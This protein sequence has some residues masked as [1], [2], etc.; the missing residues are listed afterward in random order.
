MDRVSFQE[1]LSRLH[2]VVIRRRR[3]VTAALLGLATVTGLDALRPATPPTAGVWVAAHD[4]TGGQALRS[5][6]LRIEQ[7]PRQDVPAGTFRPGES[8][9]GRLL[10]TPARTGE[11][12]TNV[13]LVSGDL[14]TAMGATG[15]VA[16]PI[17]VADAAATAAVTTAGAVIDV[18][19]ATGATGE[20]PAHLVASGLRVL[21]V[22]SRG[23]SH[24][25]GAVLVVAANP[26]Q[27]DTLAGA[28]ASGTLSI[29]LRRPA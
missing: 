11:P 29:V 19:A 1:L 27:A 28:A 5:A 6:D 7:L 26:R 12:I 24:D 9:V 8:L 25:G 20:Q 3:F 18:L 21:S 22:P 4:L 13:R 14:L 16:V 10:S 2:T 15:D 23:Q 17:H